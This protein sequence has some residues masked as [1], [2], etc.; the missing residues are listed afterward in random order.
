MV[1]RV[2]HQ[3]SNLNMSAVQAAASTDKDGRLVSGA[4]AFPWVGGAWDL[5]GWNIGGLDLGV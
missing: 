4:V 3:L 2:L 1:R 5:I